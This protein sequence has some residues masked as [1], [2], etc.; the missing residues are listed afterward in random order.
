MIWTKSQRGVIALLVA[1]L[2]IYLTIVW[3][4]N[5]QV[6]PRPLVDD[7]PRAKELA[8]RID[9]NTAMVDEL[10]VLPEMGEKRAREVAEYRK[11]FAIDHPKGEKAFEKAEDLLK[12][13]G[14]GVS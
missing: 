8:D 5:P 11:Q 1:G 7:G 4:R 9:P 12:V 10:A 6:V 14:I 3:W 13:K 2:L